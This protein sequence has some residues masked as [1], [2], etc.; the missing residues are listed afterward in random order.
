MHTI[1]TI[2]DAV[3]AAVARTPNAHNPVDLHPTEGLT[4]ATCLNTGPDGTHCIAAQVLVDLY[5]EGVLPTHSNSVTV[6]STITDGGIEGD[7]ELAA[8]DFF[9]EVQAHFDSGYTKREET[10]QESLTS[11]EAKW[12]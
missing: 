9:E 12:N 3:R 8:I 1:E 10:W 6:S 7:F 5:H 2:K 4:A 11:L